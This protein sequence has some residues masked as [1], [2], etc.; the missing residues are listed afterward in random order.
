[1]AACCCDTAGRKRGSLCGTCPW[2]CGVA[3]WGRGSS[4]LNGPVCVFCT[5]FVTYPSTEAGAGFE[6]RPQCHL[7]SL[8]HPEAVTTVHPGHHHFE[9]GPSHSLLGHLDSGARLSPFHGEDTEASGHRGL[10]QE[11]GEVRE[12]LLSVGLSTLL[13]GAMG[14]R[15]GGRRAGKVTCSPEHRPRFKMG[16]KLLWPRPLSWSPRPGGQ[17]RVA[18]GWSYIGDLRFPIPF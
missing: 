11:G 12:R 4:A 7:Q 18:R 5:F 16:L 9:D 14:T 13:Q 10:A 2:G 8:S 17:G 15:C 1:M 6:R 3:P